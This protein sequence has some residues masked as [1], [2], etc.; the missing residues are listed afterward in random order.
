[1]DPKRDK[2]ITFTLTGH[3]HL[4]PVW[5]WDKQ[6]GAETVKATFRSAL[7]RMQENPDLVFAH[8]SA[9]QYAWMEIHPELLGEIR[10]A[11]DRG[12]WEPAGGFW[13][14]PDMNI[15]SGESLARQGLYGQRFFEHILGRRCNVAF[16]PDSF[17]HPVTLPQ[18][19]KQCGLDWFLFWRPGKGEVNVP[20][21]LFTWEGPD[22]T[23]I[24]S[25][26]IESYNSNPN[27]VID[28]MNASIDWRPEDASEWIVLYG[29]GNHGGGPTIKAIKNLRELNES[30]E[31]P[32][33]RMGRMDEFFRRAEARQHPVFN[34]PLQHIFR[35]CYTSFA[36][37]KKLNRQ[38][39]TALG[40]AEKWSVI[41]N[42]FGLPYPSVQFEE[43][44]RAVLFN[45]FHDI[46]CGTSIPRA[47]AE[48][49]HEMGG[50]I[51]FGHHTLH[52][53]ML[54]IG[55][56]IDTRSGDHKVEE[57]MRRVRTGPGN[58]VADLGDGIPVVVFNHSPWPRREVIDVEVN[59]WH[60]PEMLVLDE[61]QRPVVSQFTKAEARH[62][63]KRTAFVAEVPPMGYR[64]YRL[65]DQ[66]AAAPAED[67]RLLQ[68]DE[69][70]LENDWWRLEIDPR[71]GALRSLKD[72]S[73]D[74]E[75]LTGG[76]AQL[77]VIED[78]TNAWG[79]GSHFRH[80]A[81]VFAEP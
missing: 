11:V 32:N 15:P 70:M 80:L 22:G 35:G 55:Q 57:A 49:A 42:R 34:E 23:R 28:T 67:A 27:N 25:A 81:G 38:G 26:R 31:W 63:R 69:T 7:D 21:N 51:H 53:A 56:Q 1:M 17:G 39:E 14:E 12:Q 65:V 62:P 16:L 77:L 36:Q 37:V 29:V 41:A 5:L 30:P 64:V 24:L 44:W 71:T 50:A 76:G 2:S 45:Q 33:L 74:A 79:V 59:D 20:S 72:K 73:L 52:Q 54:V 19:F 6:E 40:A 68:A 3:A 4:D 10:Q 46:I 18:I 9:A 13:V 66:P 75:L 48:V 78:P 61:Q 8:S 43:A 47:Y 58:A 60:V